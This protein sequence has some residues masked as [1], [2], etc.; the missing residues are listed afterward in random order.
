[1]RVESTALEQRLLKPAPVADER[2]HGGAMAQD[3]APSL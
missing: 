2:G 3:H 1:M